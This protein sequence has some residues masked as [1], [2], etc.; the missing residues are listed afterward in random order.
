MNKPIRKLLAFMLM[1]A[2]SISLSSPVNAGYDTS[3]VFTMVGEDKFYMDGAKLMK[4][5]KMVVDFRSLTY[6][7]GKVELN[8][9]IMNTLLIT[10]LAN[11][12]FMGHPIIYAVGMVFKNEQDNPDD[13]SSYRRMMLRLGTPYIVIL[14]YNLDQTRDMEWYRGYDL[15]LEAYIPLDDI[16]DYPYNTEVIDDPDQQADWKTLYRYS[17][18][19]V[20][21]RI[22]MSQYESQTAYIL[23]QDMPDDNVPSEHIKVFRFDTDRDLKPEQKFRPEFYMTLDWIKSNGKKYGKYDIRLDRFYL[24]ESGRNNITVYNFGDE[25]SIAMDCDIREYTSPK[26]KGIYWQRTDQLPVGDDPMD[27]FTKTK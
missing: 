19:V 1:I 17:A 9:D 10:D 22:I 8:K 3:K 4:D 27:G 12:T 13:T 24:K 16:W 2:L 25:I 21:P 18:K 20:H 23:S 14:S 26:L 7:D 15:M 5:G 11:N 6:T